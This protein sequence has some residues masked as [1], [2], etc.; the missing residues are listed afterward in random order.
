[1]CYARTVEPDPAIAEAIATLIQRLDWSGIFNIQ[2]ID[3]PDGPQLIDVNPRLY[4]SL[5]LAV[6]AGAN[7]PAVWAALMVGSGPPETEYRRGLPF[8]SEEDLRAVLRLARE[9]R[10][11]AAMRGFVP[12]RRTVHAVLNRRDPGPM[13]ALLKH[14]RRPGEGVIGP[15]RRGRVT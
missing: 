2:L 8:R 1:V 5:A 10:I 13:V 14:A 12:R 4:H 6:V 9:G 11:G 7:L 15:E 3:A